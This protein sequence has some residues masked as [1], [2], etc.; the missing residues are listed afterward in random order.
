MS[1]RRLDRQLVLEAPDVLGDGAGGFVTGW[2]PLG[3]LWAQVSPR[4]GRETAQSGAPVSRMAYRITVR[5]SPIG[6]VAR[7]AAQQR[8]RE[9]DRI[10]T[11]EAV[12][13]AD[14]QGRYLICF[15]QEEQVV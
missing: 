12:A 14:V 5:A 2:V 3:V 6:H 7:P 4:S 9:G 11:I 10:F 8:F 1:V 13:E 15:A